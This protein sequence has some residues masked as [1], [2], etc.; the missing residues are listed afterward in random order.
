LFRSGLGRRLV[1]FGFLG[2]GDL[3]PDLSGSEAG[4]ARKKANDLA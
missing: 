3:D 4:G 2:F 1:F